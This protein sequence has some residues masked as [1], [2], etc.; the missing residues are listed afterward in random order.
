MELV[1]TGPRFDDLRV[2]QDPQ[3]RQLEVF[4]D[5]RRPKFILG[6]PVRLSEIP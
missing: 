4:I 3:Q 6:L 2:R 1:P 5:L